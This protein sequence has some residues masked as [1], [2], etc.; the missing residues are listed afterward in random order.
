M[1]KKDTRKLH[2]RLQISECELLQRVDNYLSEPKPISE[3]ID[4]LKVDKSTALKYAKKVKKEHLVIINR[5]RKFWSTKFKTEREVV[6]Y[7]QNLMDQDYSNEKISELLGTNTTSVWNFTKKHNILRPRHKLKDK[8]WL[9]DMYVNKQMS[10]LEIAKILDVSGTAVQQYLAKYQIPRRDASARQKLGAIKRYNLIVPYIQK[11]KS[12][13][14]RG[15]CIRYQKYFCR[16][17]NEFVWILMNE[18]QISD[19]KKEPFVFHNYVPDF[20][21]N[22]EKIIEVKGRKSDLSQ[23]NLTRY[24][25]ISRMFSEELKYDFEICYVL[26]KYPDEYRRVHQYIKSM[27]AKLGVTFVVPEDFDSKII[28]ESN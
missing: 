24:D 13:C 7:I 14:S 23:E 28:L 19:I 21:I 27:G 3:L 17:I 1:R 12:Y 9:F 22:N 18:R 25:Q 6:N 11:N 8:N 20:L 10:A 4:Y 26:E 16:S 5:N 15:Y 2:V